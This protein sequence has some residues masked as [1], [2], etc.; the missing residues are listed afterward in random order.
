MGEEPRPNPIVILTITVILIAFGCLI[1]WPRDAPARALPAPAAVPTLQPTPA[2][3]VPPRLASPPQVVNSGDGN[4]TI[5]YHY[6]VTN[7]DA[8]VCIALVC[9]P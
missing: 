9:P 7:V 2:L 1:V 5:S 8:E 3:A 6:E 4:V